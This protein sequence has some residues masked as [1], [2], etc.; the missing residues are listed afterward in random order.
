[1][2]AIDWAFITIDPVLIAPYRWFGNPL[3]GWW[4]GTFALA[5]WAALIGDMCATLA[6]WVNRHQIA[7]NSRQTLY[8][9]EQ[10]IAAKKAGDELAYK[11]I[12]DLANEAFGKSFFLLMATGMASLWPAFFAAAWMHR[13]FSE[14]GYSLPSWLGGF[15]INPIAPFIL[16]YILSRLLVGRIRRL[17]NGISSTRASDDE[18]PPHT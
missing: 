15:E 18:A 6:V 1:M 16:L 3:L 8:Y 10:S 2:D 9:H 12:N 17:K 14:L 13:R 11:G 5:L 7:K 4:V